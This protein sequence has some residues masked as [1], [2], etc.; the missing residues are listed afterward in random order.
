MI[1]PT[2]IDNIFDAIR[3]IGDELPS[4]MVAYSKSGYVLSLNKRW[5]GSMICLLEWILGDWYKFELDVDSEG[6]LW[7]EVFEYLRD[8]LHVEFFL[9]FRYERSDWKYL[10]VF[11]EAVKEDD[12]SSAIQ[13]RANAI[14]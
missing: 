7:V 6:D 12:A 3:I 2:D 13:Q 4:Q 14:L 10:Q 1:F 9:K 5:S 11:L 8:L